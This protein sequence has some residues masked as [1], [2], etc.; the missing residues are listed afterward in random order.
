MGPHAHWL[1]RVCPV[2]VSDVDCWAPVGRLC[3]YAPDLFAAI[4]G[5]G[6][7][8]LKEALFQN[9]WARDVLG[10]PTT[11]VLCRYLLV[12]R[13]LADVVLDPLQSDRFI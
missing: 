5:A 2:A 13:L 10:E 4:S 8:T 3:I 7:R 1:T 6:K 12:W 11:Q 9:R